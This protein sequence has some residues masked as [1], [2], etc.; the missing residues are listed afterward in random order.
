ML[1]IIIKSTEHFD[2]HHGNPGLCGT[3]FLSHSLTCFQYN[4]SYFLSPYKINKSFLHR[5]SFIRCTSFAEY[6][7]SNRSM[8][9]SL[10]RTMSIQDCMITADFLK[11]LVPS[12]KIKRNVTVTQFLLNYYT[13]PISM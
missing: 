13:L 4:T 8:M 5:L 3:Q 7:G 2:I 6:H 12:E 9:R 11:L 10:S 1:V